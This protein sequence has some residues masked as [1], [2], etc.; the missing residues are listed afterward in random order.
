MLLSLLV[1]SVILAAGLSV[2]RIIIR[3]ISLASI[4]KD[5]QMAF[6]AADAGIEC[7]RYL[8]ETSPDVLKCN[9]SELKNTENPSTNLTASDLTANDGTEFSFNTGGDSI[10]DPDGKDISVPINCV[11]II[12]CTGASGGSGDCI[13]DPT[14]PN[15]KIIARGYNVSCDPTSGKPEGDRIVERKLVYIYN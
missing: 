4:Q 10:T 2:T 6:F 7:G 8:K 3:Q 13:P 15:G 14:A 9:G 1:S 5:S 11:K 12:V